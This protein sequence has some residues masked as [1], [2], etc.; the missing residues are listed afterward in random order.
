[1]SS[2]RLGARVYWDEKKV[3]SSMM[4]KVEQM[5]KAKYHA[6]WKLPTKYSMGTKT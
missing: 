5:A 6:Q 3:Q 1:M 2:Y 4:P